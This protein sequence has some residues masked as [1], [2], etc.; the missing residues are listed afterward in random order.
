[1]G[2]VAQ[3]DLIKG[4]NVDQARERLLASA[5]GRLSKDVQSHY[6]LE[7]ISLV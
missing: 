5:L 3:A 2:L 6:G 7:P 1:V 4:Y